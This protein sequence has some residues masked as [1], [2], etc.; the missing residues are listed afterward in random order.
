[1]TTKR[2]KRP[3]DVIAPVLVF[4]GPAPKIAI[5]DNPAKEAAAVGGA[6]IGER[7]RASCLPHEIGLFVHAEP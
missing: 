6:W 5:L 7:L 2:L 1:M 3:R 4:N